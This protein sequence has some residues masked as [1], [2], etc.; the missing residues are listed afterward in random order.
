MKRALKYRIRILALLTLGA[1]LFVACRQAFDI[2][3]EPQD[4]SPILVVEGY[5]NMGNTES[6][7]KLGYARQVEVGAGASS[8]LDFNTPVTNASITIE[9]ES[10]VKY[11]SSTAAASGGQ[12]L[13][14]HP[15]LDPGQRYRLHIRIGQ[16]EYESEF[17]EVRIS[18]EIGTLE[19]ERNDKGIQVFVNTADPDNQSRYY[20]W[21]FEETWKYTPNWRSIYILEDGEVRFREP[22]E[23]VHACYMS[24]HSSSIYLGTSED[25]SNDAIH[26]FPLAFVPALSDKM[27]DGYSILVRQIVMTEQSYSYWKQLK[28]S[29]EKLGD[30]FGPMPSELRGNLVCTTQPNNHVIGVVEAIRTAE[31]RM[32]IS[33]SE[34]VDHLP[35][36]NE[37]YAGC[38]LEAGSVVEAINFVTNNPNFL[39]VQE[40]QDNPDDAAIT[41]YSYSTRACVDC[42]VRGG[43]VDMPDFWPERIF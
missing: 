31:K 10:G 20:R 41:G 19:W 15:V 37:Y 33:R 14:R 43:T 17:V 11:Y 40:V 35:V 5:I 32:F 23:F 21:E 12:Y 9:S 29:S 18:P 6:N 7:Y 3:Y 38:R 25:L 36:I 39:L 27:T 13:I 16:T 30:L 4:S 28:E 8:F 34:L 42:R 1:C 2:E 24:Q 26:H 22:D